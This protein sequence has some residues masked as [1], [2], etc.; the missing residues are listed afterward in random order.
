MNSREKIANQILQRVYK[1]NEKYLASK[2]IHDHI[3]ASVKASFVIQ[4][5]MK[6]HEAHECLDKAEKKDEDVAW[7]GTEMDRSC[8]A[9]EF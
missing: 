8:F 5:C 4:K 7:K 2:G 3:D 1:A 6:L 9:K